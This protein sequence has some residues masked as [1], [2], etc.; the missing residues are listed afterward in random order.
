[1]AFL[2]VLDPKEDTSL[3]LDGKKVVVPQGKAIRTTYT[4]SSFSQSEYLVYKESQNRI[5]YLL[6]MKFSY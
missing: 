5:R 3:E 6:K 2:F 4:S 1:L